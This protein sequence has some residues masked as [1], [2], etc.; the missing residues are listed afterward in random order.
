MI[1]THESHYR[2]LVLLPHRDAARELRAR[3]ERL[4]RSGVRGARSLPAAVFLARLSRPLRPQELAAAARELRAAT[5]SGE[6]GGAVVLRNLAA[7]LSLPELPRDAVLEEYPQPFVPIGWPIQPAGRDRPEAPPLAFRAA[8]LANLS[9][10][11]NELDGGNLRFRWEAGK[12]FWLPAPHRSA[13][14]R[15]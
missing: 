10:R 7:E 3:L 14:S 8:A 6:S 1:E 12:S 2:Y 11:V 9:L 4:F 13:G 5:E 15:R